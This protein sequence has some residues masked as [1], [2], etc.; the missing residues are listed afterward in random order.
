MRTPALL[1]L[2]HLCAVIPDKLH[3]FSGDEWNLQSSPE[4]WT[5]KQILGH[6]I[7]S[8]TNNHHRFIR[9]QFHDKP[10]IDYHAES[11][12]NANYYQELDPHHLVNFW[13]IYNQHIANVIGQMPAEMMQREC[14]S[15]DE[16]PHT[17]EWLFDDYVMHLEHHLHQ[18]VEYT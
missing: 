10:S 4:K 9:A 5:K 14:Y 1:R 6:L 13:L 18:L 3:S 15:G 12:V 11:W 17:L 7:D 16:T 8:A 2:E